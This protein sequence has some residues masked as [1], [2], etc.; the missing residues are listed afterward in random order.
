MRTAPL[1]AGTLLTLLCSTL[2]H[3]EPPAL[4]RA[5]LQR[6]DVPAGDYEAVLA[7]AELPGGARI[8]R[9]THAGPEE[10][11]VLTGELTLEVEG[12]PNRTLRPGDSYVIPA[13][14]PHDGAA[15]GTTSA[16]VVVVYVVKKGAPLAT[17]APAAAPAA[18]AR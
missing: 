1:A 5:L 7:T 6:V 11:T 9:H 2:A 3:A 12:Q 13:G 16:K 15:H 4:K 10:G 14:V 17:P 8:G 18:P